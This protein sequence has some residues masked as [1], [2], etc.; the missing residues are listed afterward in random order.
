MDI[1]N[2]M[3]VTLIWKPPGLTSSDKPDWGAS[4]NTCASLDLRGRV[5]YP[6][7]MRGKR[8][9]VGRG[10]K[11]VVGPW[12]GEVMAVGGGG[13]GLSWVVGPGRHTKL[14]AGSAGWGHSGL[15]GAPPQGWPWSPASGP[16]AVSGKKWSVQS[17][18]GGAGGQAGGRRHDGKQAAGE[19][20]AR[21]GGTGV[22]PQLHN[23][24]PT[25]GTRHL[26][27]G[28]FSFCFML[29]F[30]TPLPS[31][32]SSPDRRGS[33][34][35]CLLHQSCTPARRVSSRG[36]TSIS[37]RPRRVWKEKAE[38]QVER[39]VRIYFSWPP[40]PHIAPRVLDSIA[41]THA[42]NPYPVGGLWVGAF[43]CIVW[44]WPPDKEKTFWVRTVTVKILERH[45]QIHLNRNKDD[46]VLC[47][48]VVPMDT[49]AFGVL[50]NVPYLTPNPNPLLAPQGSPL[51]PLPF[52]FLR[53]SSPYLPTLM[54]STTTHPRPIPDPS[55][56]KLGVMYFW[57]LPY[58]VLGVGVVASSAASKSL[59]FIIFFYFFL[60]EPWGDETFH[61]RQ[62]L[63]RPAWIRLAKAPTGLTDPPRENV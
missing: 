25:P 29:Y 63:P 60:L 21:A 5:G 47:N 36:L 32:S 58:L 46:S 10:G 42:S 56:T 1:D 34:V 2:A 35:E 44:V 16:A 3:I 55:P 9:I 37:P 24:W 33:A 45:S 7:K 53:L 39:L 54:G 48:L 13:R 12:C 43:W 4:G 57:H 23:A 31:P 6:K 19:L 41:V 40:S 49:G 15:G 59:F 62:T 20:G 26:K 52:P 28:R 22:R 51:L 38:T 30:H 18:Q 8:F 50:K 27:A 61:R 11:K 14:M 17:V